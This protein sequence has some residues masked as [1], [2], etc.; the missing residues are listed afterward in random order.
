MNK[1]QKILI[2]FI[3]AILLIVIICLFNAFRFDSKQI[4]TKAVK[5]YFFDK[6]CINRLSKAIQFK[7]ISPQDNH[8]IDTSE[9]L[10]FH[11]YLKESFPLIN[12][13]LNVKKINGL[14][15]LYKWEGTDKNLKPILLMAH[16]DVVPVDLSSQKKWA[17]DPFSGKQ[18]NGFVYGRGSLDV[19]S[20]LIAHMEAVEFLIKSG[21]KPRRTIYLA[22]GHDE[23]TGGHDGAKKIVEFLSKSGVK[24]D[25]VLDE[26]GSIVSE[27][28]PGL[29]KPIALVGVAE[30][31]YLSLELTVA[32]AG[33]HSSMPPKETAIGVLSAALLK[34]EENPFPLKI[35]GA[36]T[37]L[38]D[39]LAPEMS[40]GARLAFGNRWLFAPF[41]KWKL[42]ENNATRAILHTT[43][44]ATIFSSGNKENVLPTSARAIVNFRI[45]PGESI[46]SVQQFVE[47]IIHDKRVKIHKTNQ[48]CYEPSLVSNPDSERFIQLQKTISS[49]FPNVLVAPFLAVGSTDSRHYQ[50]LTNNIYRFVPFRFSKDD[51]PRV[52]GLNERISIST[53]YESINFYIHLIRNSSIE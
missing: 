33:G 39:Y 53:F 8:L 49:I 13:Q 24:L 5:P 47:N 28:I 22:Y 46:S 7:T 11:A 35:G 44:A 32:D 12:K 17:F 50:P 19:K 37:L 4:K 10:A 16:Q 45:I 1:K 38:F 43:T 51:L 27:M 3:L 30:K 41:I 21:Y 40:F 42:G 31:G 20:A 15:L 36:G 6:L 23:E 52:H 29:T 2:G 25:F 14:S 26:G 9:Y 18:S 34:L 48:F